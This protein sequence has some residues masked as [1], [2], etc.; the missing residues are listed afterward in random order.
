MKRSMK[1]SLTVAALVATSS[2]SMA[3]ATLIGPS[4]YLGSA[5]SPFS[6]AAGFT[7]FHL[8]NFE[9]HLLNT[10][11][12]TASAGVV[13]SRVFGGSLNDSVDADDGLVNGNGSRGDNLFFGSGNTGIS[14]IFDAR[15]LGSLPDAVGIVWTD[16]GGTISFEAF[17][18]LNQSLGVLLGSHADGSFSGTTSEDRFYGATSPGGI[19]RM[20]ISNT[21]GGIEVDHLQYGLRGNISNV[22]EPAT[23]ALMGIGLAG[24][25]GTRRRMSTPRVTDEITDPRFALSDRQG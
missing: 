21:L 19:S 15:V 25:A 5:G 13:A 7:Y 3:H 1:S 8:E 6:P 4:P 10:P 14:F 9:D 18:A 16:G 24:F 17:D 12:V 23:L 22:P 11:G 20:R 2:I